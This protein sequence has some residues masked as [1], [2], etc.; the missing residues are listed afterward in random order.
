MS[1]ESFALNHK[2]YQ[3]KA[4]IKTI[5]NITNQDEEE[6]DEDDI[7]MEEFYI[8]KY[9][10][11]DE[12]LYNFEFDI[13]GLMLKDVKKVTLKAPNGKK[14]EFKIKDKLGLNSLQS[15]ADDYTSY[16]D[17]KK[18]FPEGKYTFE[19]LPKKFG[20]L[21][22]YMSHDFPPVPEITY[23]EDG[24]ADMPL[25]FIIEWESLNEEVD[26]LRLHIDNDDAIDSD[27][28]FDISVTGD[29]S[30]SIPS[31]LLRPNTEY[32]IE[33]SAFRYAKVSNVP[34]ENGRVRTTKRINF[35]TGS[36]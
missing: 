30:F 2:H 8:Q 4:K 17:F 31:G 28:S 3:G 10:E 24:A 15:E 27:L 9:V 7:V 12:E 20:N 16:E 33:L 5:Q 19:F 11:S 32:R 1:F 14:A 13:N 22:V 23:P 6:D 25:S 26:N 36:E 29:T 21:I 18:S 35:T 34:D